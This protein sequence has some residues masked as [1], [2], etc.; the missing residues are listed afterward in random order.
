ML[1]RIVAIS[2]TLSDDQ[3][4]SPIAGFFKWIFRTLVQQL[5]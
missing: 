5:A 2:M 4:H 1:Y 3:G